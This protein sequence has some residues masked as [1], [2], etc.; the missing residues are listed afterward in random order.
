MIRYSNY[1]DSGVEWIG[2]IPEH[3]EISTIKYHTKFNTNTLPEIT[4]PNYEI[5]YVEISD[6]SGD[7]EIT[8]TTHYK[9]SDAPSRCRRV[10]KS[11][12]VFISTVRTY[13]KA[14]GHI[15]QEV[16]NLICSTG[17]CVLSGSVK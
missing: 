3:W 16:K 17:F 13:L 5:N 6:V 4:D 7:G 8:N 14:I 12:D 9:F 2:E 15:E 10:L 11:G 1:K